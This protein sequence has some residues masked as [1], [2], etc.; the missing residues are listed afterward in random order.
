MPQDY[1][2]ARFRKEGRNEELQKM[3]NY[4]R[5]VE[6]VL[7]EMIDDGMS[8]AGA[9]QRHNIK[10]NSFRN[11]ITNVASYEIPDDIRKVEDCRIDDIYFSPEEL[12]WIELFYPNKHISNMPIDVAESINTIIKE[13]LTPREQAMI[14]DHYWEGL[15]YEEMGQKYDVTR[16][17]VR[18][19][20]AKALRRMRHPKWAKSLLLNGQTM[21]KKLELERIEH[22]ISEKNIYLTRLIGAESN[23]EAMNKMIDACNAISIVSGVDIPDIKTMVPTTLNEFL[24]AEETELSVRSYN[25]LRRSY[26]LLH[27]CDT[28]DGSIYLKDLTLNKLMQVRNLGRKSCDEIKE[29]L[30]KYGYKI[31]TEEE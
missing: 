3:L 2:K 26:K 24:K 5:N 30:L 17:R 21:A 13:R 14:Y 29:L 6:A 15:T 28:H 8:E 7:I 31:H 25:C 4:T 27:D 23:L 1:T 11:F 12:I 16:E 19:I 9:C 10:R 22:D 20:L 18:Q